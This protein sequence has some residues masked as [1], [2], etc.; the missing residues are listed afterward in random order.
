MDLRAAPIPDYDPGVLEDV[1]DAEEQKETLP[2]EPQQAKPP[3]VSTVP[4]GE[5]S[6]I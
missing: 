1:S 5:R 4:A 6:E 2:H 3:E